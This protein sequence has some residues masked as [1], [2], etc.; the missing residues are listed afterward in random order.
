MN[1]TMIII[2]PDEMKNHN[3]NDLHEIN[4]PRHSPRRVNLIYIFS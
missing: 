3:T 1:Q 2:S 4:R